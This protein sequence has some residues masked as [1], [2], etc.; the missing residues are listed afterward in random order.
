MGEKR[1]GMYNSDSCVKTRQ[2]KTTEIWFDLGSEAPG[3]NFRAEM[4]QY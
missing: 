2:D 4:R 3:K 1:G